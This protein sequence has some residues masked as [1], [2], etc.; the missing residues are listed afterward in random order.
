MNRLRVGLHVPGNVLVACKE[1]NNEKRRDD[2]RTV[3]LLAHSGWES[4]LSHDGAR[5]TVPCRT[6]HYW[7]DVWTDKAERSLRLGENLRKL[8][9][10]R[11]AFPEFQ[12]VLSSLT[13]RRSTLLAKLYIDCQVFAEREIS[14]LLS[15]LESAASNAP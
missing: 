4:F 12:Q 10:F 1:C 6:C 11:R 2:S 15:D 13:E 14:S 7:Q 8:Q 3:L 5:C 9:S